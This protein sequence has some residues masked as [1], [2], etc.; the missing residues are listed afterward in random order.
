MEKIM[1]DRIC[2][3]C[4][5]V[6]T[7]KSQQSLIQAN[8]KNAKCYTC[9]FSYRKKM[10]K[11]EEKNRKKQATE[12][13][14]LKIKYHV[15]DYLSKHPCIDCGESNILFLEF[16]HKNNKT[17]WVSYLIRKH[18]SI[19]HIDEEIKKCEVRCIG[20]HR[21]RHF[22]NSLSKYMTFKKE[23]LINKS[24]LDCGKSDY[25]IL[26]FDHVSGKKNKNVSTLMAQKYSKT[27]VF[28]E[29]QKCDIVCCN[30]HRIR[31]ATRGKW[32][33]L[34]YIKSHNKSYIQS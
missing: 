2:P 14:K 8:K 29:I 13:Y 12:K 19:Q 15:W 28:D 18:A 25:R 31:T 16:D 10:S 9:A 30:C 26:E 24:C 6:L 33:I 32:K 23:Y 5:K 11:S 20:C 22:P 1:Y 3:E 34:E 17:E 27:K 4:K 7:Y 21:K